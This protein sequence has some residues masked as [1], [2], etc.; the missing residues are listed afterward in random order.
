[1]EEASDSEDREPDYF[2]RG[3]LVPEIEEDVF[4]LKV[5][6]ISP[7]F[8]IDSGFLIFRLEDRLPET[9]PRYEEVE[10]KA[11]EAVREQKKQKAFEEM[12]KRLFDKY[13]VVFAKTAAP[14][15]SQSAG[16]GNNPEAAT[17]TGKIIHQSIPQDQSTLLGTI[18]IEGKGG[19]KTSVDITP[20]TAFFK[21]I[22][23]GKEPANF[24]DLKKE[25]WVEV[26]PIGPARQTYPVQVNAGTIVI[27]PAAP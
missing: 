20:Q 22:A 6:E 27:L 21:K 1:M 7:V 2:A 12:E 11:R 15:S 26:A 17:L 14:D 8:R 16:P 18:I 5:G 25:Q 13:R 24:S 19:D 23:Q 4:R 10:C 3:R 9:V